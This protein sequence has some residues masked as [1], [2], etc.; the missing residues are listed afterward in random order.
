[1]PLEIVSRTEWG[2]KAA[3]E[4]EHINKAVPFVIIHH[5]YTPAA[6]FTSE[7]CIEAMQSMQNFH[8]ITRG[9]WDIGYT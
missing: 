6:C 1:M 7:K 8:Q 4:I 3:K 5:S 9:W 2:S